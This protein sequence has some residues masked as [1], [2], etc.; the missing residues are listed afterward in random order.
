MRTDRLA[1]GRNLAPRQRSGNQEEYQEGGVLHGC[2]PLLRSCMSP[3]QS[4]LLSLSTATKVSV[5]VFFRPENFMSE[6][7][8]PLP[9]FCA[10]HGLQAAPE[11][12]AT[13]AMC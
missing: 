9:W 1:F 10:K 4:A 11:N 2:V 5:M 6:V 12:S 8:T 3:R 13:L 7:Q